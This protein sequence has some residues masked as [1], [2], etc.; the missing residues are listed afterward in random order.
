[1][2][3]T[4]PYIKMA[5]RGLAVEHNEDFNPGCAYSVQHSD[6]VYHCV[7]GQ[8]FVN[9]GIPLPPGKENESTVG[10]MFVPVDDGDTWVYSHS[11]EGEPVLFDIQALLLL[12]EVQKT[13]DSEGQTVTWGEAIRQA[14]GA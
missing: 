6:R 11:E 8:L 10:S 1:M 2:L 9:E 13:A 3:F 12:G 14:I 7:V 4:L 5:L